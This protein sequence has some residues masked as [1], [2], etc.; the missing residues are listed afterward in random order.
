MKSG[1]S[2]NLADDPAPLLLDTHVI[3]WMATGDPRL[4]R[5]DIAALADPQ[6]KLFVS[7]VVAFELS[8][9]QRRGRVA[10][11]EPI[12][13]LQPQMN[14]ELVALP[15]D[16][17]TVANTLPDIHRDPVDRMLVAHALVSGM[18]LVTAD[19]T[20]RRYPVPCL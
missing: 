17:W 4:R 13:I 5:V 1:S 15:F 12:D 6:R 3:I 11:T 19:A 10:M 9:L 2:V 20:I 8:D 7:A 16:V 14:F 18:T